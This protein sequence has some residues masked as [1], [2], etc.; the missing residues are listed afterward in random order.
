MLQAN[1][2][3]LKVLMKPLEE[4]KQQGLGEKKFA[5]CL[6]DEQIGKIVEVRN[7]NI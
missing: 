4:L 5:G 2:D 3:N 7:D 6:D 1:L